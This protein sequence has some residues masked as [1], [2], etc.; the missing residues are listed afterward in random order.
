[1]N[2]LIAVSTGIFAGT[3][4]GIVP[5]AGVMVAM[6]VATPLLMHFDV[7]QLLLFYMSLASMVQFT[8]TIP[9][10][11]LGVP[12][13][14]NSLPAVIEGTKF[15]KRKLAKLA[16]G[17]CAIGSVLGS[18]VAVLITFGLISILVEHMTIFFSNATKFY[19]YIFIIAFCILVYNKRKILINLML[20]VTG[21]ALSL[22]GE[23]D[24]SPEFRYTLGI[25]SLQF[26]IPLIP[27]LIGFLIVPTMTKMF[28]TS[29]PNVFLPN[30]DV[31]IC[32]VIKHFRKKLVASSLRGGFI[33][34]LCG[35][36]PGV[37]TVLSTNASYSFEKKLHPNNP[38]KLLVAS[39]TANNA[40]QFASMLPLLLIG[41]PITGSEIVLYS[42]LVDAGWSPFQFDNVS[43]NA[44]MIFKQIVPWF[45]F[46]NLIGL[47]VAW[48]LAKKV[49]QIFA[50]NKKYLVV[51]LGVGMLLLNT[52][53]GMLDY[54]VIL[55]TT[56]LIVFGCV[57]LLI[58]KYETV[59]L[60][61]MFILG[62]D[63]E[64][65]FYR[66]MLI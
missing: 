60:V 45:V 61:F 55:Y 25:D 57:G 30:I 22:P 15:N 65:V 12:G 44:D 38:G 6:I 64:G 39:E 50:H 16:I 2:E 14:T 46:A 41:I 7:I 33:G 17:I 23:S 52:Y 58:R 20:C 49:L 24:I 35:F 66:Q 27:I 54:R 8:G 28:Y 10:V 9:A 62:N 59:P 13:E 37:S 19:L 26:G 32:K 40:G 34:Y 31:G 21:Y 53:L 56:C 18:L 11:Y 29:N 51:I 43:T 47:V 5:G 1:M 63:I 4:T 48:P 3:I 42:L 36:V